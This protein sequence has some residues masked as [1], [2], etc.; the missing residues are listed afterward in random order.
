MTPAN[1]P[2]N[3]LNI[4]GTL[5]GTLNIMIPAKDSG[6]LFNEPTK[7]CVVGLVWCKNH[8]DVKLIAKPSTPLI[9]ATTQNMGIRNAGIEK[10]SRSK[11]RMRMKPKGMESRLF[12]RTIENSF[13][14]PETVFCFARSITF[15]RRKE[16][17]DVQKQFTICHA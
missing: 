15:L 2:K 5:V 9:V 17:A 1:S 13:K 6:I 7:L 14:V 16:Y 10:M 4:F 11:I 3:I 12:S 8:I